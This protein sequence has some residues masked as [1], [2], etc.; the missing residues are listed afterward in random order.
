M[1]GICLIRAKKEPAQHEDWI[2]KGQNTLRRQPAELPTRDQWPSATLS[3]PEGA[4]N[5]L[6]ICRLNQYYRK[7]LDVLENRGP[8]IKGDSTTVDGKVV[9]LTPV[10]SQKAKTIA[11][12]QKKLTDA[13]C[14][15]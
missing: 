2:R 4:W 1:A 15:K 6:V 12:I 3:R 14:E 10:L 13:H 7:A 11:E 8:T 9:S 5:L